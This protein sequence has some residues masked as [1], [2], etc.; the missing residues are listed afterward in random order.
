MPLGWPICFFLSFPGSKVWGVGVGVE[1]GVGA[2]RTYLVRVRPD[3][4]EGPKVELD[5]AEHDLPGDAKAGDEVLL[6]GRHGHSFSS[7]ANFER[8]GGFFAFGNGKKQES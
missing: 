4:C 3:G 6:L 5:V 7:Y 8:L 2:D 1:V